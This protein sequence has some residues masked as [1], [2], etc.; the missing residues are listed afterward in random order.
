MRRI[1]DDLKR[2]IYDHKF[3]QEI[4]QIPDKQWRN[5]GDKIEKPFG[6]SSSSSSSSRA[7]NDDCEPFKLYFKGLFSN[8]RVGESSSKKMVSIAGVGAAV[9]DPQGNLILNIQ[10]PLVGDWKSDWEAHNLQ[11][12]A[13]IEGL[14]AAL[15]LDIKKVDCYCNFHPLYQ[16][17]TMRWLVQQQ[18]IRSLVDQVFLL[19]R[20]FDRCHF[21][22]VARKDVKFAFKL[23]RGAIDSQVTKSAESSR[24]KDSQESC[25]ICLEDIDAGKMF[26]VDG[27]LHRYCI[28][29]MR[30]HVEVKLLHGVV[31][32]CPH[33]GC[34]TQLNIT[35]CRKFLSPELIDRMSQRIAEASIPVTEKLYCPYPRCS[36]LMSK[37]EV[38]PC[39]D[40]V[41]NG[42]DRSAIGQCIKCRRLFCI[43]CKVPWH[44]NLSCIEYKKSNTK[45]NAEDAKLK[46]LATTQAW[47]QCIKCNHMIELVEG[48]YHMTCRCGYEFCYTCGAEWRNKKP[49]CRC[50]IWDESNIVHDRQRRRLR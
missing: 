30:Q 11:L 41:Y 3:A 31:P 48:C 32:G 24:S 46:S 34:T 45:S 33:E 10:K 15:S 26:S 27:C 5:Y 25:S 37:S 21:F 16:Y 36:V 14:N 23:A 40:N 20:K 6:E 29:C 28:S 13:L 39:T 1:R 8:E 47:H 19:Q 18:K 4:L 22:H 9:C 35:S 44:H 38:L 42:V 17:I 12:K 2:R 49:T 50:P 7:R 43:N